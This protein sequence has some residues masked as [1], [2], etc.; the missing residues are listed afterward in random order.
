MTEPDDD[1]QAGGT[2]KSVERALQLISLLADGA[3]DGI[4]PR[5][6]ARRLGIG[7][8]TAH[9][10]LV[11]LESQGFAL[12]DPAN[13]RYQPGSRLIGGAMHLLESFDIR[14]A[15]LPLMRRVVAACNETI[16]LAMPREDYYVFAE[17]VQS[18]N[19]VKYVVE[20]GSMIPLHAGAAGKAIL[21]LLPPARVGQVL[22]G[23]LPR[24]TERTIVD[25]EAM[26]QE[27]EQVRQRGYAVSIR[28]RMSEAAG[29]AAPFGNPA[30]R[31]HGC[32]TLTIPASRF[33]SADTERLADLV[34]AAAADLNQLLGVG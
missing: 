10:L 13:Q 28:E 5:E 14:N 15:A 19:P 29:V 1:H 32:L 11:T 7:K 33:N 9:R 16:Y 18:A 22:A 3:P 2:L 6:V 26:R 4:G 12:Q 24:L 25:P 27:L 30:T 21:S 8:S 34:R 20:L 23:P 17:R 31:L